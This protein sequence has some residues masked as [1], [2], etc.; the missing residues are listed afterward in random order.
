MLQDK[1]SIEKT[2][3]DKA[4]IEFKIH[5]VQKYEW[6]GSQ[7][8][9]SMRGHSWVSKYKRLCVCCELHCDLYPDGLDYRH[10]S[11]IFQNDD[12]QDARGHDRILRSPKHYFTASQRWQL[13]VCPRTRFNK[14]GLR[15]SGWSMD[16]S[17][18]LEGGL[19]VSECRS[20][21]YT[22]NQRSIWTHLT[23]CMCI[24]WNES[25]FYGK[26]TLFQEP[27]LLL[28]RHRLTAL[29]KMKFFLCL[30]VRV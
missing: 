24:W 16:A 14:I 5:E 26:N 7:G 15:E 28:F 25:V 23:V 9:G 1:M 10:L 22:S 18:F 19:C 30:E 4:L 8:Q 17:D 3:H 11:H 6:S 27:V 20:Y 21:R 2:G 29:E 12:F 13:N